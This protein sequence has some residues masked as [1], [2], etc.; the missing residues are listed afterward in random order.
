[1]FCPFII[2]IEMS[3]TFQPLCTLTYTYTVNYFFTLVQQTVFVY[4][5]IVNWLGVKYLFYMLRLQRP[6]KEAFSYK[7][8]SRSEKGRLFVS[9]SVIKVCTKFAY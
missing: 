1:M 3:V 5:C 7:S 6:H 2:N 9:V 8:N 4:N